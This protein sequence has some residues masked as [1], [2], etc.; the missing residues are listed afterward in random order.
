MRLLV[1]VIISTAFFMG[2]SEQKVAENLANSAP[3]PTSSYKT[4]RVIHGEQVANS[5]VVGLGISNTNNIDNIYDRAA[6]A[7]TL[8]SESGTYDSVTGGFLNVLSEIA[9]AACES[10]VYDQERGKLSI[11]ANSNVTDNRSYFRGIWLEATAPSGNAASLV[12][13]DYELTT[14]NYNSAYSQNIRYRNA[15][16]RL[17]RTLWGRDITQTEEDEIMNLVTTTL[18]GGAANRGYR[19]SIMVCTV[20]ASSFDFVRQ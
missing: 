20:M 16:K 18:A 17:A 8:M 5:L 10:L 15:I 7:Q 9:E 1:I 4:D 12:S 19:A 2:C 14:A 6:A 13:S 11:D 3:L